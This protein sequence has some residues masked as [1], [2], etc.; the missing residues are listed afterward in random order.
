MD[1]HNN[2][3]SCIIDPH[4]TYV[5]DIHIILNWYPENHIY[6]LLDFRNNI[7]LMLL[8]F[9]A[10]YNKYKIK[11]PKYIMYKIYITFLKIRFN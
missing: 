1:S 8:I 6:H 3:S 11:I 5:D 4:F 10:N 7:I 2:K 9:K